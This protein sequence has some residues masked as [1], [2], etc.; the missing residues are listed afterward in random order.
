MRPEHTLTGAASSTSLLLVDVPFLPWNIHMAPL[1]PPME[2][3]L[4]LCSWCG[5][6]W[7]PYLAPFPSPAFQHSPSPF[8][9]LLYQHLTHDY[10]VVYLS[11]QNVTFM[12]TRVQIFPFITGLPVC[13]TVPGTWEDYSVYMLHE[14]NGQIVIY[15]MNFLVWTVAKQVWKPQSQMEMFEYVLHKQWLKTQVRKGCDV[16]LSF[17]IWQDA[18]FAFQC[19]W[20]LHGLCQGQPGRGDMTNSLYLLLRWLLSAR[21]P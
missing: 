14:L 8:S 7:L 17:C 11:Q 18:L 5:L 12:R 15:K 1:P 20:Q 16:K 4:M 2:L 6:S 19:C 10:I 9:D 13:R 21:F 3:C